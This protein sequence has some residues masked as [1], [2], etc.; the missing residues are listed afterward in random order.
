MTGKTFTTLTE[1]F[2]SFHEG[3][4]SQ[5]TKPA[6]VEACKGAFMAGAQACMVL[7]RDQAEA[8][9]REGNL[10]DDE[11]YAKTVNDILTNLFAEAQTYFK[12]VQISR[13]SRK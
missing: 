3:A 5:Y 1:A 7:I 2:D 6:V 12:L 9:D 11:D 10:L 8:K 13:R 4:L